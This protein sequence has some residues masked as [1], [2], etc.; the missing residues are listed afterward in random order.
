MSLARL[1][2][3]QT[4]FFRSTRARLARMPQPLTSLAR[5]KPPSR[6]S[7][8]CSAT[9]GTPS[10]PP[11][12]LHIAAVIVSAGRERLFSSLR[13]S[14]EK[15]VQRG[16]PVHPSTLVPA[17]R[18]TRRGALRS[19][20]LRE[21]LAREHPHHSLAR[22]TEPTDVGGGTLRRYI[23][24]LLCLQGGLPRQGFLAVGKGVGNP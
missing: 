17:V 21:V 12:L 11:S 14:R 6:A 10:A 3:N 16:P 7:S 18:P 9:N 23:H 8:P 5:G 4:G 15:R 22:G 20:G 19:D 13:R 1:F 24:R 2:Y